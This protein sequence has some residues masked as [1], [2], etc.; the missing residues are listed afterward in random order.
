MPESLRDIVRRYLEPHGGVLTVEVTEE[1]AV[2]GAKRWWRARVVAEG[3]QS[4]AVCEGLGKH[5]ARRL[6]AELARSPVFTP[7]AGSKPS[8]CWIEL[9][10][11][12]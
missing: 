7:P 11:E 2:V 3:I 12:K 1:R 4:A 6:G 10:R 9:S 8:S 5:L